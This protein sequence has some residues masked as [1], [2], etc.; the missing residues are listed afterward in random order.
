LLLAIIAAPL[1]S[2][3]P[4]PHFFT[5]GFGDLFA[6][7]AVVGYVL[8][9]PAPSEWRQLW[10]REYIGLLLILAA[11]FLSLALSPVWDQ[12]VRYGIK[13]G[14][15]E[16]AGYCLAMAYLA[17]LAHEVHDRLDIKAVLHAVVAAIF[18]VALFSL[19]SLGWSLTCVGGYGART[20]LTVNGAIT[21]VLTNPNYHASYLVAMLPLALWFYLRAPHRSWARRFA[22]TAALFLVFFVQ[23]ALSR[24]GL[25][26]LAVVWIGWL[27]I[28]RWE[29]GTRMMTVIFGLML[30]MTV[31][32][33]SYPTYI[34]DPN[35]YSGESKGIV[36]NSSGESMRIKFAMDHSKGFVD[37]GLVVR[38]ALAKN[39]IQ[40]WR[41]HPGTGVG[42]GLLA[43]Y[44][45][46]DE[47]ANRAH[48]VILT[49]LA[50]QGIV[51]L[52]A[53]TGWLASLLAV[54]WH[55]RRQLAER[56]HP[57]AF[58]FLA[59]VGMVVQGMFMDF[60]RVIWLW[61]LGAV[62]L[63]WATIGFDSN[64]RENTQ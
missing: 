1:L 51:G 59:F 56:G 48:N 45:S 3:P 42:A 62:V 17:I 19:A 55:A 18:I 11:A 44:S 53:W 57:S 15:A 14:L 32:L 20:A 33:W 58:L 29:R 24:S 47:H 25:I 28:T 22:A 61:Q 36:N 2:A 54:F 8:R 52:M 50:E 37:G 49:I 10:R 13:Y 16:I 30:A 38:I 26:G 27:M 6:V 5:Q 40:A 9:H 23:A 4:I 43:N 46:V 34:C 21:S 12:Q 41:D 63:A 64:E 39:A 60:Y 35:N 7:C 31:T